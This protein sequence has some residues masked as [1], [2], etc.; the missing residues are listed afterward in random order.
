MDT[1][2]LQDFF[3]FSISFILFLSAITLP[4]FQPMLKPV[5]VLVKVQGNDGY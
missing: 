2:S 1:L 5:A 3:T 4:P